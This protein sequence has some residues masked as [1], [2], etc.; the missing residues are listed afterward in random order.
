MKKILFTLF[1]IS[2]FPQFVLGAAIGTRNEVT[3]SAANFGFNIPFSSISSIIALNHPLDAAAGAATDFCYLTPMRATGAGGLYQVTSGKTAYLFEYDWGNG[4]APSIWG[5]AD[6][7]ASTTSLRQA[8]AP[9]NPVYFGVNATDGLF[10]N[11]KF[12]SFPSG[13]YPFGI[14]GNTGQAI[15]G[16]VYVTEQ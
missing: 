16:I 3:F 15:G 2:V 5:Y 13:K 12:M 1:V 8:T 14:C 7:P 4:Q 6:A 9:T 11:P 10:T